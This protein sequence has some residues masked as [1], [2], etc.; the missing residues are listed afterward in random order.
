[1]I[2]KLQ[3]ITLMTALV[4]VSLGAAPGQTAPQQIAPDATKDG[5]GG[6]GWCWMWPTPPG[7]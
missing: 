2:K 6:I 4:F 7:C 1:M 3:A 5:T